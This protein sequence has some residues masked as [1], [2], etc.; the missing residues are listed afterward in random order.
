MYLL[1]VGCLIFLS[2]RDI[3]LSLFFR[4]L[5]VWMICW[6]FVCSFEFI[7]VKIFRC[8][9]LWIF[10][11]LMLENFVFSFENFF[12]ICLYWLILVSSFFMILKFWG[13]IWL[14]MIVLRNK[15]NNMV[16]YFVYFCIL[17]NKL[18][19]LLDF[20]FRIIIVEI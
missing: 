4:R 3:F 5:F 16:L 17:G 10:W 12:W 20:G 7:E 19:K 18:K 1:E 14:R 13:I 2:L 6:S 9:F 8:M 15:I 11:I